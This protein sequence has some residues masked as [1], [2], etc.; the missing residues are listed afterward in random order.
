MLA[1]LW[2]WSNFHTQV[3]FFVN[4]LFWT[5]QLGYHPKRWWASSLR[6]AAPKFDQMC[7][8]SLPC[9]HT[10]GICGGGA[11]SKFK[12][13]KTWIN[14]LGISGTIRF[15]HIPDGRQNFY[16]LYSSH[17]LGLHIEF[18]PPPKQKDSS[19]LWLHH[20]QLTDRAIKRSEKQ[21]STNKFC[22]CPD[23]L[24][25]TRSFILFKNQN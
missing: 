16:H 2:F 20:P 10:I 24:A 5:I 3:S 12:H 21:M 15:L 8:V 13:L 9:P 25:I 7:L 6:I 14:V 18:V 11:E 17:P 19:Y 22:M 4:F 1:N 23:K